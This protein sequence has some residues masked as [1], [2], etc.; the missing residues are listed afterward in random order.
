[1]SP[2]LS[3]PVAW[4]PH[5]QQPLLDEELLTIVSVKNKFELASAKIEVQQSFKR[6][7]T[8]LAFK[9][10]NFTPIVEIKDFI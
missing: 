8:M 9:N 6:I 7:K 2:L 5:H 4:L 10:L 1:M 3:E